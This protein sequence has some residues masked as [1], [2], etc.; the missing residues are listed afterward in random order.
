M[1]FKDLNNII[2]QYWHIS[3][4]LF[5]ILTIKIKLTQ[6]LKLDYYFNLNGQVFPEAF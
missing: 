4:S 6:K 2:L 1:C 3:I 5:C